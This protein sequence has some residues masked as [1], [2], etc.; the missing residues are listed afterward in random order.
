M[1]PIQLREDL[2]KE[3]APPL[4][5][6]DGAPPFRDLWEAEAFAIGNLLIKEGVI[7]CKE[8]ETVMSEAILRAQAAGDPD[9]GD[10]Y[11]NHWADALETILISHGMTDRESLSEQQ[12]LWDRAIRNTPH[13]VALS[14]EN[15]YLTPDHGHHHEHEDE[16]EHDHDHHH[17]DHGHHHD[18]DHGHD[19][20]H[21]PVDAETVRRLIT[22]VAVVG[23]DG[24]V[25]GEEGE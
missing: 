7:T 6:D 24:D 5:R 9:R 15:A 11:F 1:T 17:H 20:V 19:H 23:V 14:L 22:P 13:G 18:H 12:A 25:V 16:H 3:P 4:L 8:W 21:G 2:L 10:T